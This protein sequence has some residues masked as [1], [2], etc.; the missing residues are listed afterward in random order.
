M[1]E[2]KKKIILTAIE[3]FNQNGVGNVRVHDIAKAAQISPGNLTYHFPTKKALM[4]AVYIYMKSR[5]EEFNLK[6]DQSDIVIDA[7]K[8]TRDYLNFQVK[9]RFFYRD[10]LE[11]IKLYP[12][13]RQAYRKR[14]QNVIDFNRKLIQMAVQQGYMQAESH[15]GQYDMLARNAW[16]LLNSWLIEQEI[17]GTNILEGVKASLELHYPYFTKKGQGFYDKMIEVLP[18]L[19]AAENMQNLE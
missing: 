4:E 3:L 16:A 1:K 11:I 13:I 9:F 17:M 12:D 15:Q 10:T 8:K 19:A 14:I 2:S 7:L 18:K 5:L 6:S